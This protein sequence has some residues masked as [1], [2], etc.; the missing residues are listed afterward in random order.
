MTPTTPA[1]TATPVSNEQQFAYLD[2][3]RKTVNVYDSAIVYPMLKT[4]L[5]LSGAASR[6]LIESWLLSFGEGKRPGLRKFAMSSESV[7]WEFDPANLPRA[8]SK[9]GKYKAE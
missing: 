2:K 9:N 5:G 8:K 7:K 6:K 4:D 1:T 3:L